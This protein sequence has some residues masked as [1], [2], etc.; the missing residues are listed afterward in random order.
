MAIW[1]FDTWLLPRSEVHDRFGSIETAIP[2]DVFS[3]I[4]W[5]E[6]YQPPS[7]WMLRI[8][9]VLPRYT[10]WSSGIIGW[11][12]DEGDRIHVGIDRER[13]QHVEDVAVRVDM[14]NYSSA[15]IGAIVELARDFDCVLWTEPGMVI[16]PEY[17]ALVDAIGKSRSY[18]FVRDPLKYLDVL[19]KSGESE[20]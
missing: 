6:N 20:E 12:S 4:D 15:F 10:T 3:E 5:W 7:D 14:R 8:D 17:E 13:D 11:G 1:Q 16:I 18:S 2:S 19:P 9:Q